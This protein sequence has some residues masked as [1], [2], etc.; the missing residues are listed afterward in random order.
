MT[1]IEWAVC[2]DHAED[3]RETGEIKEARSYRELEDGFDDSNSQMGV[4]SD[5]V[6]K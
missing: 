5:I 4:K 2:E 6:S 1:T 3:V